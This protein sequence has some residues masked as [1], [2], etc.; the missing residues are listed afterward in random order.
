[1]A[2]KKRRAEKQPAKFLY[3]E[4]L[5]N[6]K[7]R[8]EAIPWDYAEKTGETFT[9]PDGKQCLLFDGVIYKEG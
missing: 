1:M 6:G 2:L 5:V 3:G 4:R 7:I 9:D 8:H